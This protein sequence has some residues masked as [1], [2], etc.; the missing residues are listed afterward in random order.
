MSGSEEQLSPTDVL[1]HEH[2]VILLVVDAMERQAAAIRAGGPLD[3]EAVE[4]MVEFTREFS[5]G[6]HHAKEERVLF[7]TLQEASPM[8]NGP[9]TVMLGEHDQGRAY[10]RAITAALPAAAAGDEAA[11]MTVADNLAGYATL[12]RMHIEQE[13][14]VLFPFA[15]RTLSAEDTAHLAREFERIEEEETGAGVHEIYDAMAHEL[16]GHGEQ[17]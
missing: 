5:D 7:P 6:C 8:A 17:E 14:Q 3:A 15:E 10:V 1:R 13:N 9:V 11:K 12:L 2:T 16:A 4:K